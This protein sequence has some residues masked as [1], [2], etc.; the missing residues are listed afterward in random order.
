[1]TFLAASGLRL[2][3]GLALLQKDGFD[4]RH[5]ALQLAQPVG[6]AQLAA[7]VLEA[8]F[9]QLLALLLEQ[10]LELGGVAA[11]Q[12]FGNDDVGFW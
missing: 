11:T 2:A 10:T 6:L 12:L 1:M 9:V 3:L 5:V 4:P 7:G 8:L